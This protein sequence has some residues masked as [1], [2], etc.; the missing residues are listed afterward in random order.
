MATALMANR[1][2]GTFPTLFER[3]EESERE[4]ADLNHKDYVPSVAQNP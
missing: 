2:K 3:I 1:E 4:S